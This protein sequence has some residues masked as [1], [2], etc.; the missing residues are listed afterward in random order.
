M[1]KP[2]KVIVVDDDDGFRASTERFL[3]SVGY[4]VESYADPARLLD[5]ADDDGPSCVLLDLR[6]PGMSGLELQDALARRGHSPHIVFMSGHADVAAGVQAMKRGAVDFL[7]KPFEEEQVLE[8]IERSLRRDEEEL[9]VATARHDAVHRLRRL[10][11]R[12]RQVCDFLMQGLL[13]K[14]VAAALGIAESTVKVHRSR[15]MEKLGVDSLV[16]LTR[17]M[18]HASAGAGPGADPAD[19]AAEGAAPR[20]VAREDRA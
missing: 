9:A 13:N 14:Q 1:T 12:E 4:L 20:N 8:A 7:I 11:A 2:G 17:L 16:G 3:R 18:D 15:M 19:D 5:R 6:M 10:T